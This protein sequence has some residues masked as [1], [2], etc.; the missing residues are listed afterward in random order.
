MD[1]I[2]PALV[3]TVKLPEHREQVVIL[4]TGAEAQSSSLLQA[5]RHPFRNIGK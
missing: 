4:Q 1:S 5:R 2:T 3:P